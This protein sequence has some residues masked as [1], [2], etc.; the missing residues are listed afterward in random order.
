MSKLYTDT[1]YQKHNPCTQVYELVEQLIGQ[2]DELNK[3]I[4][5]EYE[6]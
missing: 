4:M 3:Q 5:K 1:K 6:S 2:D